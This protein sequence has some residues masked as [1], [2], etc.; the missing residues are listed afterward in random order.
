MNLHTVARALAGVVNGT[1]V[2]MDFGLIRLP[3]TTGGFAA[4]TCASA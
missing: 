4:I 2:L 3:A 1:Q